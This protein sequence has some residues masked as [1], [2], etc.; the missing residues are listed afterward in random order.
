VTL[1]TDDPHISGTDLALEWQIALSEAGFVTSDLAQV[2]QNAV[3][4]CFLPAAEKADLARRL[5]QGV[6]AT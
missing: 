3:E 4:T 1:N 6:P 2:T 5:G